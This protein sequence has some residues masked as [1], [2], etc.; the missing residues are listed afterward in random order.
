MGRNLAVLS[1]VSRDPANMVSAGSAVEVTKSPS[2]F[3]NVLVF[4]PQTQ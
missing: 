2:G 1:H 4:L 3:P